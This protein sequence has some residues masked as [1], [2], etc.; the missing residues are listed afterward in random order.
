MFTAFAFII[1]ASLKSENVTLVDKNKE[2]RFQLLN[3]T[4]LLNIQI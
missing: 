1:S 2:L 3:F 4:S